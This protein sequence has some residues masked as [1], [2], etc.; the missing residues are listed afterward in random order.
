MVKKETAISGILEKWKS[1]LQAEL[2]S[3]LPR[4]LAG[5]LSSSSALFACVGPCGRAR[6]RFVFSTVRCFLCSRALFMFCGEISDSF[7][8]V[9]ALC[10]CSPSVVWNE[11]RGVCMKAG[12]GVADRCGEEEEEE[13]RALWRRFRSF[14]GVLYLVNLLLRSVL[15]S[16]A[17]EEF[18]SLSLLCFPCAGVSFCGFS[19]SV[20]VEEDFL[21]DLWEVCMLL[22]LR[23]AGESITG[24]WVERF[25]SC[26]SRVFSTGRTERWI[27]SNG[28]VLC[29]RIFRSKLEKAIFFLFNRCADRGIVFFFVTNSLREK[30]K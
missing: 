15:E 2:T 16:F 20:V 3:F 4:W 11:V 22:L 24:W 23:I 8:P 21:P 17:A 19:F 18:F 7:C 28:F 5:C 9:F 1:I 25:A 10:D 12:A 30:K 6:A 29:E 14:V 26:N 27:F 13:Y